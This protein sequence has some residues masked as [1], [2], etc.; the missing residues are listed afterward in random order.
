MIEDPL[1]VEAGRWRHTAM[2][3]VGGIGSGC[4]FA[5]DGNATLGREESRSGR[6]LDRR[7]Y[8]KLHIVSH[9]VRRLLGPT[10]TTIPVGLVGD[11]G[12]GRQLLAEMEAVGLDIRFVRVVG[13]APTLYSFCFLYPDGSGGNLTTADSAA[14]RLDAAHVETVAEEFGKHEGRGV[15]LAVPEA[16]LMARRAL[17]EIGTRHGFF[18]V[19]AFT[20]GEIVEQNARHL[21]HRCDLL[22]LNREEAA[23]L[24]ARTVAASSAAIVEAT[25]Q[26]TATHHRQLMLSI[27]AG[28]DGSWLWDGTELR[29]VPALD[30]AAVNTAGAGDAHLAGLIAGLAAGL[31]PADAHQLAVLAAALSVTS[32]HTIAQEL[33]RPTLCRL[34]HS[35][36]VPLSAPL[37]KLL[38]ATGEQPNRMTPEAEG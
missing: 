13:D 19:G 6:F 31:P 22:A 38:G 28:R 9:Y 3:G 5:L 15:A 11:D 16:P 20:T 18:R 35:M 24:A 29:H 21:A 10:F 2:I 17:L 12:H 36:A 33:C 32:P 34:A 1:H 4:F 7:D 8:C 37:T 27:T 30:V 23:A 26:W 25:L 14:S